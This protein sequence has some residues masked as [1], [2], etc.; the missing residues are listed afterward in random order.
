MDYYSLLSISDKSLYQ[1]LYDR[2]SCAEP[3]VLSPENT[4]SK[5]LPAVDLPLE[6]GINSR[7]E[8]E[9]ANRLIFNENQRKHNLAEFGK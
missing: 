3:E 8:R 9:E 2:Y 4:L 6:G 1:S 7:K 5:V